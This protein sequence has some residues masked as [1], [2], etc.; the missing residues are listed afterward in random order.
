[1]E[2]DMRERKKKQRKREE[3]RGTRNEQASVFRATTE[4]FAIKPSGTIKGSER[5]GEYGILR[6]V[7]LEQFDKP[8]MATG[9]RMLKPSGGMSA[10]N[11]ACRH[12]MLFNSAFITRKTQLG[13]SQPPRV[14]AAR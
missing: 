11:V 12:R 5:E 3:G 4:K 2:K 7:S 9:R 14:L 10:V 8:M 13:V 6:G 1:M